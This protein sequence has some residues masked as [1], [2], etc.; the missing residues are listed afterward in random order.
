MPRLCLPPPPAAK[1]LCQI[2]LPAWWPSVP[3]TLCWALAR[4]PCRAPRTAQ[5]PRPRGTQ[6]THP[7]HHATLPVAPTSPH[8]EAT[9]GAGAALGPCSPSNLCLPA[10]VA[11]EGGGGVLRSEHTEVRDP[12]RTGVA[13]MEGTSRRWSSPLLYGEESETQKQRR[14]LPRP[15][16]CE[17]EPPGC[18]LG[19]PG[20]ALPSPCWTQLLGP[21]GGR[22]Q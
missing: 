1:S 10:G 19:H 22:G 2:G 16:S 11:G 3:V 7:T 15:A 5:Q 12:L 4:L 21:R 8:P 6:P 13:G 14:S 18:G 20:R 9:Q 17:R